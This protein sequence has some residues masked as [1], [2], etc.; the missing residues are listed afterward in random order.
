ML[1]LGPHGGRIIR[2]ERAGAL[3]TDIVSYVTDGHILLEW[4][5]ALDEMTREEQGFDPTVERLSD[6]PDHEEATIAQL[7]REKLTPFLP[8]AHKS[9]Q[10]HPVHKV[11][12]Y[13]DIQG[14]DERQVL[15]WLPFVE[16]AST[17]GPGSR[18][19]PCF[20]AK[21]NKVFLLKDSWREIV[22]EKEWETIRQLNKADVPYVPTVVCAG[23]IPDQLTTTQELVNEEWRM[24]HVDESEAIGARQHERQLYREVGRPVIAMRSSKEFMYVIYHAFLG[25]IPPFLCGGSI[26]DIFLPGHQYAFQQGV[27]HQNVNLSSIFLVDWKLLRAVNNEPEPVPKPLPEWRKKETKLDGALQH[28]GGILLDWHLSLHREGAE[29]WDRSSRRHEPSVSFLP[30]SCIASSNFSR[31]GRGNSCLRDLA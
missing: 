23:D 20:E 25:E 2:S 3:I 15:I 9:L 21:T 24:R 19:Y 16:S 14:E 28:I 29:D 30:I 8:D 13:S 1:Y 18:I 11:T 12:V 4:L 6:A 31:R 7:A 22:L 17:V 26:V 10:D 5:L 27:L